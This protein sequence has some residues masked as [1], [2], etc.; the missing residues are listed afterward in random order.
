MNQY[1]YAVLDYAE[2]F[3]DGRCF[4]SMLDESE[5]EG[6]AQAAAEHLDSECFWGAD[7]EEGVLLIEVF[8]ED[9][10]SLGLFEVH[11]RLVASFSIYPKNKSIDSMN[12]AGGSHG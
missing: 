12:Q 5:V 10:L 1:R 2:Q 6:L 8:K 3:E 9:G 4:K 7:S 11:K